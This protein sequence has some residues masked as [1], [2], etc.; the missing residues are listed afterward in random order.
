M[1]K[2]K[3]DRLIITKG[4]YEGNKAKFNDKDSGSVI[5]IKFNP[6]EYSVDESNTYSETAIP[7]LDS[8]IIQ[9]N[10][11]K[12]KTLSLELLIDTYTYD[13]G[14]DI[15]K[16]Y[17]DKLD[18][19]IEVDGS[20]HAP[21]PCKVH[22]SSLIFVGV[23]ESIKKKFVL[24][25]SDGIPVRARVSL[26]FKEYVPVEIQVKKIKRSSPDKYKSRIIA[27][28]DSLWFMA[29][30]EY[31]SPAYWR[32]IAENNKI[33]NPLMLEPG[34]EITLPPLKK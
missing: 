3:L 20:I 6:T 10:S 17:I 16:K 33:D 27:E 22:W 24:F 32:Y 2:E 21:P 28:G 18:E 4:T 9:F 14:V 19:L 23:L 34:R 8:P 25:K 1:A 31:G 12:A 29:Y 26:S 13:K 15:R 30:K 5:K 11:G 7:G